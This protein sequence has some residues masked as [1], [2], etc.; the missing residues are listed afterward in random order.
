MT[1]TDKNQ[2]IPASLVDR[3]HHEEC[4]HECNFDCKIMMDLRA[5]AAAEIEKL[6]YGLSERNR[7]KIKM[8]DEIDDLRAEAERL[9]AALEDMLRDEYMVEIMPA[10]AEIARKALKL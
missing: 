2:I 10:T 8:I 4:D 6:K 3:L 7:I 1:D 5:E 9:R